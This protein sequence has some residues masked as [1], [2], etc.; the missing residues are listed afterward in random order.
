MPRLVEYCAKWGRSDD[1]ILLGPKH[2]NTFNFLEFA[3]QQGWETE[4][5]LRL[6]TTLIA[7]MDTDRKGGGGDRF[8]QDS[9][10]QLM[11]NLIDVI[12]YSRQPL[13]VKSMYDAV[14]DAPRSPEQVHSKDWQSNS[15]LFQ[16]IREGEAVPKTESQQADFDLACQYMLSEFPQMAERTRTSVVM[17]FTSFVNKLMRGSLRDLFCTTTTVTP[18][19]TFEGKI[20]ILDMPIKHLGP[21]GRIGQTLFRYVWQIETEKRDVNRNPIP[22]FQFIDEAHLFCNSYDFE[23]QSTARSARCASIWLSQNESNFHAALGGEGI[24]KARTDALM[25]HFLTKFW[26]GNDHVE[27]NT[28]ASEIIGKEWTFRSSYS[29]SSSENVSAHDR[30]SETQG[31]NIGG[32]ESLEYVIQPSDFTRLKKPSAPDLTTEAIIFQTG[33]IWKASGK[34]SLLTAFPLV[35]D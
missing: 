16:C 10:D 27:T 6:F 26:H 30:L 29:R 18:A 5:I 15:F 8:W 11:V 34:T 25:G 35:L 4:Q 12:R 32:A 19:D 13:S 31:N 20:L 14:L 23:F 17:T 7:M 2:S 1:V 21:L 33:R 3:V 28:H 9:R 22:V 24:G